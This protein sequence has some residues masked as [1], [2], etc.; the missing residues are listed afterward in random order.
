MATAYMRS[1]N[2]ASCMKYCPDENVRV[3]AATVAYFIMMM[4]IVITRP[5]DND[6]Y[7]SMIYTR[8]AFELKDT[9]DRNLFSKGSY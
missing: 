3:K 2:W 7:N 6:Y 1:V 8:F 4:I 5:S 9:F